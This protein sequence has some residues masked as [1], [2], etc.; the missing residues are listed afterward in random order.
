MSQLF[1]SDG[2]SIGS[3]ASVLTINIQ[4]WFLL[5]LTD[6]IS[7]QSK[8]LS[9]VFSSTTV[10]K[11]QFFSTQPSLWSNSHIHR[12]LL[13]KPQLWLDQIFGKVM[14]LLFN[15]L[16]RLVIAFLP[17]SKCLLIS[18]LQSP[19]VVIWGPQKIKPVTISIGFSSIYNEMIGPD[20]MILVFWMFSFKP[21]FQ[22]SSFTFTKRFF[23]A[24]SRSAIRV[25]SAACLKLLIFPLEILIPACDLSS[26]L[27]HMM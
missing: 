6:L 5:G 12:W 17:K 23:S 13:E 8:G 10:Q 24:S 18:W 2:Q 4:S 19:S 20:A 16:P 9:S 7:L 11:H 1:P 27:F 14:F 25:V 21:A 3:L 15:M 22:L 26:P